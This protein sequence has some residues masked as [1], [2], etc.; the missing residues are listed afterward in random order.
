MRLSVNGGTASAASFWTRGKTGLRGIERRARHGVRHRSRIPEI[1]F[2]EDHGGRIQFLSLLILAPI[3][4]VAGVLKQRELVSHYTLSD[5]LLG[6][7]P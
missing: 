2:Q 7:L 6:V 3:V 1:D 5:S 4:V